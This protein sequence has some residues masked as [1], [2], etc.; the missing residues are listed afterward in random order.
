MRLNKI[1]L[2]SKKEFKSYITSPATYV[3]IGIFFVLSGFMFV[4]FLDYFDEECKKVA[5]QAVTLKLQALDVNVFVLQS[6]FKNIETLS[7]V[8]FPILT[9]KLFSEERKNKTLELLMTSPI[10]SLEIVLGKFFSMY[11]LWFFVLL[12]LLIYPFIIM[13]LPAVTVDWLTFLSGMLG[14][15]LYGLLGIS[16][17]MIASVLTEN[18]F[19]SAIIA[20]ATMTLLYYVFVL[21]IYADSAFGEFFYII[22]TYS[23][24]DAFI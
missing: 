17:G 2:I 3:I 19:I 11:A 8:F 1:G 20:F 24:F 23:H 14:V 12:F 13:H 22:S 15:F 18:N 6:H 9:M 4:G 10:S 7:L 21:G 16:I 5:Q